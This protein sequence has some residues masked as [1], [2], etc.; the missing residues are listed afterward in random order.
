LRTIAVVNLKGGSGK[1]TVALSL[2]VGLARSLPKGRRLLIVDADPQGNA[3]L[4]ML[5]GKAPADPTLTDVL[6]GDSEAG[7]AI[8]PSR[9]PSIDIMPADASLAECTVLLVEE[10][11][12]ELKLRAA[13]Q[14][15][16]DKYDICIID[17]PPQMSLISINVMNAARELIVPVDPGIYSASGLGRLE[18]TVQQVRKNLC[19]P[20]LSIIGLILTKLMKN[21]AARDFERQLREHY[22]PLVYAAAIP[23]SVR[24]E[25]ACARHLTVLEYA[26]TSPAAAAFDR[27]IKELATHGKRTN[28]TAGRN[29]GSNRSAARKK[30]R[31]G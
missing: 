4:T 28:G 22:G 26:P 25:E 14:S 7:E 17:A 5:Q 31:A 8:R 21:K 15:I 13:L 27:L 30:R 1:T 19:H 10:M 20:E 2:A 12:R 23:Y 3:S 24:V 9:L 16:E 6:L 11:G 29:H 18:E